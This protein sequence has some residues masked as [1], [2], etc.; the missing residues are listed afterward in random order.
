MPCRMCIPNPA[1]TIQFNALT[2]QAVKQGEQ[3]AKLGVG[4]PKTFQQQRATAE[5]NVKVGG[6]PPASV[7]LHVYLPVARWPSH[8][9]PC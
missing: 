3:A 7:E 1:L 9:S 4:D 2:L 5:K 8:C 6:F